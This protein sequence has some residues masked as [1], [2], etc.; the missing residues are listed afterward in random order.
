[1]TI[2]IN[3]Y[4]EYTVIILDD[5]I[6]CGCQKFQVSDLDTFIA[7]YNPSKELIAEGWA[8]YTGELTQLEEYQDLSKHENSEVRVAVAKHFNTPV[9][10]LKVLSMYDYY[11]TRVAVASNPNTPIDVFSVLSKDVYAAVRKAVAKNTNTPNELLKILSTDVDAWVR[12]AV[13]CNPN[14]CKVL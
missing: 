13:A 1:M 9:E 12:E 5:Y 10:I 2:L 6:Y 14:F 11:L 3:K 7:E 4:K 8:K